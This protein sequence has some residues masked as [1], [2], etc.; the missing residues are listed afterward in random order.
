MR[1]DIGTFIG[2]AVLGVVCT[3]GYQAIKAGVQVVKDKKALNE[4]VED[5]E[6]ITQLMKE[7][8]KIKH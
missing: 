2:S 4:A 6:N 1:K 3:L 8:Q 5:Y 7:A